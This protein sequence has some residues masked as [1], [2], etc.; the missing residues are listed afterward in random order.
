MGRAPT[1]K[2][3]ILGLPP[4]QKFAKAIYDN[5]QKQYLAYRVNRG[6]IRV[7]KKLIHDAVMQ[8]LGIDIDEIGKLMDV[9]G[10]MRLLFRELDKLLRDDGWEF[11]R[12]SDVAKVYRC[13]KPDAPCAWLERKLQYM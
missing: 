2:Y 13:V 1:P 12:K 4:P 3:K 8:E 7:S 9:S 10:L 6:V 11:V 5:I